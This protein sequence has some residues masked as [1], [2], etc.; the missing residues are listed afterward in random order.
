MPAKSEILTA[1]APRR[2]APRRREE[3]RARRT[4]E[5]EREREKETE[6]GARALLRN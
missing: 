4:R 5:R 6:N 1:V 2:I 3:R